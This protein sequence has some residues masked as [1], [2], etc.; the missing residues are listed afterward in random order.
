M[1]STYTNRD[2]KLTGPR[3][4]AYAI[5]YCLLMRHWT[6]AKRIFVS[7]STKSRYWSQ[8]CE[9]TEAVIEIA[10]AL[11]K[12]TN[13]V[14]PDTR[15]VKWIVEEKWGS[16][17]HIVFDVL[18]D[19]YDSKTAHLPG[20][21]NLPVISVFLS[22]EESVQTANQLLRNR[23]NEEVRETH[24]VHPAGIEPPFIVDHTNGNVPRYG[25]P[26]SGKKVD[27]LV[28]A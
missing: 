12:Q 19:T 1:E 27:H 18:H 22:R 28:E 16:R 7:I 21:N 14:E 24:R 8:A 10:L 9:S 25:C 17:T 3:K 11:A 5:L 23:V 13:L 15:D 6:T 2:A 4:S 20:H 26:R